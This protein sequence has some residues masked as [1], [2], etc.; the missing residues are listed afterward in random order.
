MPIVGQPWNVGCP[1][2]WDS[3]DEPSILGRAI[4]RTAV[5]SHHE[6]EDGK[7]C[8]KLFRYPDQCL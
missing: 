8:H 1:I 4:P 7:Q 5:A 2:P 3:D 6:H